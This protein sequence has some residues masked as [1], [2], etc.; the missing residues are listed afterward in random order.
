VQEVARKK[1]GKVIL[2]PFEDPTCL[3]KC[4]FFTASVI[5]MVNTAFESWRQDVSANI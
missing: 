5:F 4:N 2:E 1:G 3:V